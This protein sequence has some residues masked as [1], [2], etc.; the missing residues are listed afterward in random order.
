MVE[1]CARAEE[2][3][4]QSGLATLE[5]VEEQMSEEDVRRVLGLEEEGLHSLEE[6]I[7]IL[8]K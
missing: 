3:R 7:T 5:K 1:D 4:V 2:V 8:E 6:E